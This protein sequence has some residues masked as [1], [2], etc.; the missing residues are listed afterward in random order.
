MVATAREAARDPVGHGISQKRSSQG[1]SLLV[2]VDV[3]LARQL[4]GKRPTGLT[5]DRELDREEVPASH[6]SVRANL[7]LERDPE[8]V[9]SPKLSREVD[10]PREDVRE[11]VDELLELLGAEAIH[12][13]VEAGGPEARLDHARHQHSVHHEG[14]ELDLRGPSRIGVHELQ[15]AVG[16]ELEPDP[17]RNARGAVRESKGDAGPQRARGAVPGQLP[18]DEANLVGV[19]AA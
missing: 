16:I 12:V 3:A 13:A 2:E 14:R 9:S 6:R 11:R 10:L 4:H 7:P 1:P 19:V 18:R 5:A 15:R 17:V 8:R